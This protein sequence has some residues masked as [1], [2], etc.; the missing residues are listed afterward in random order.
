MP[1]SVG[2]RQNKY[3]DSSINKKSYKSLSMNLT[4]A[5]SITLLIF[6]AVS[7]TSCF[8]FKKNNRS[9]TETNNDIP[10]QSMIFTSPDD[11]PAFPGGDE[12]MRDFLSKN[13]TYPQLA[14]EKG[15]SGIVYV[16]FIV[17]QDGSL[18]DPKI[19]KGI[20][21]GCDEEAIRV[22]KLMPKWRPGKIQGNTV[23]VQFYMPL[24]FTL[25]K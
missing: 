11:T 2:I 8:L 1:Y 22:V 4:K 6:F 10:K 15:I 21:G 20:G 23:S 24:K 17:E 3:Q 16:S 12:A 18:T 19:I 9:K 13:V 14:R 7:F 5:L 25:V